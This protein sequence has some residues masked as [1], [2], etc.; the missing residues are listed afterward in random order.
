MIGIDVEQ[1]HV[2]RDCAHALHPYY[3]FI[4]PVETPLATRRWIWLG[5]ARIKHGPGVFGPGWA[6]I[7][8]GWG[9]S[10]LRARPETYGPAEW[11]WLN[12]H[13]YLNDNGT[14]GAVL[15]WDDS[16]RRGRGERT[17]PSDK[18]D[19]G[20]RLDSND[21]RTL[22]RVNHPRWRD[23]VEQHSE[24][25]YVFLKRWAR[26]MKLGEPVIGTTSFR[27]VSFGEVRRR[28][29]VVEKLRLPTAK[30][31]PKFKTSLLTEEGRRQLAIEKT[32]DVF[33][34]KWSRRSGESSLPTSERDVGGWG[35]HFGIKKA[36]KL[37][38]ICAGRRSPASG[39]TISATPSRLGRSSTGRRYP[40]SRTC[41]VTPRSR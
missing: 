35:H 2:D 36:S 30:G 11:E 9:G 28:P 26:S 33:S 17:R 6:P 14:E 1:P 16:D 39:R 12:S 41:W 34:R 4:L 25:S 23:R 24:A 13:R 37:T 22:S 19:I 5:A 29:R 15:T 7:K 10:K 20:A 27:R 32:L 8:A 3:R 40:R 21:A 38:M 31:W 18:I